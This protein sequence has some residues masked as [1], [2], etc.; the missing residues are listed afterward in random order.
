MAN[1]LIPDYENIKTAQQTLGHAN[2]QSTAHVHTQAV[3]SEVRSTHDKLVD[4]V[5]AAKRP[6][7]SDFALVGLRW[8]ENFGAD[9]LSR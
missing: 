2:S 3:A 9:S 7:T 4:I 8:P 1:Q 6:S 5:I